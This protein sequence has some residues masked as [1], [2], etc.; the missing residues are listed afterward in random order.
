MKQKKNKIILKNAKNDNER[1]ELERKF[2][3]IENRGYKKLEQGNWNEGS[4]Q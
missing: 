4:K 3:K 1:K 2:M